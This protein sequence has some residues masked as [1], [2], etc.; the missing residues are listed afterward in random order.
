MKYEEDY[1]VK[2][3]QTCSSEFLFS[4][5]SFKGHWISYLLQGAHHASEIDCE[6]SISFNI[7]L[8]SNLSLKRS[9]HYLTQHAWICL[10]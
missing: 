2:Q 9:Q 6:L 10:S 3:I 1:S 7:I 5:T 8:L 4:F